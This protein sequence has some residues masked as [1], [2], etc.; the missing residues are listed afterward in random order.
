[1]VFV[2]L[3]MV[4][5]FIA[6][7]LENFGASSEAQEPFVFHLTAWRDA[8]G[9]LDPQATG[10]LPAKDMVRL[11]TLMKKPIGIDSQAGGAFVKLR[12]LLH[13]TEKLPVDTYLVKVRKNKGAEDQRDV[14]LREISPLV[15]VDP[16]DDAAGDVSEEWVVLYKDTLMV[17]ART[18]F[19]DFAEEDAKKLFEKT[20]D[21]TGHVDLKEC[22][23]ETL[24]RWYAA[25]L[26]GR[27]FGDD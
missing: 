14:D 19:K 23:K 27:H 10:I 20:S 7:I 2:A 15:P 3:V 4:N 26:V 6:V 22:K 24:R 8:W 16:T 17:I 11:L 12:V 25:S 5:L 18:L 1:M 21:Q 13:M 9:T